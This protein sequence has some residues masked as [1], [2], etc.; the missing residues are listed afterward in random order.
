MNYRIIN[1]SELINLLERRYLIDILDE[2]L[3]S[4]NDEISS[5]YE[6]MILIHVRNEGGGDMV[7]HLNFHFRVC[8]EYESEDNEEVQIEYVDIDGFVIR[9]DAEE[10]YLK[11]GGGVWK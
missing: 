5:G 6:H 1:E 3:E 7:S 2:I 9:K 10:E 8:E 4:L 11:T